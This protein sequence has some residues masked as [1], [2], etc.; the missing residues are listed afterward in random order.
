MIELHWCGST[1]LQ[2]DAYS[3]GFLGMAVILL[4]FAELMIRGL[5]KRLKSPHEL[6]SNRMKGFSFRIYH[7]SEILW[8]LLFIMLYIFSGFFLILGSPLPRD[9]NTVPA[10]ILFIVGIVRTSRSRKDIE[11][12]YS[13]VK[14]TMKW[15]DIDLYRILIE[16]ENSNLMHIIDSP[17]TLEDLEIAAKYAERFIMFDPKTREK[18]VSKDDIMSRLRSHLEF[19]LSDESSVEYTI[20]DIYVILF[21]LSEKARFKEYAEEILSNPEILQSL[22]K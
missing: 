12:M 22:E 10:W 16:T 5:V 21:M 7:R 19:L 4:I 11:L 1:V 8:E 6:F 3:L 20:G 2:V 13:R 15:E 9:I 18:I 17:L 14:R